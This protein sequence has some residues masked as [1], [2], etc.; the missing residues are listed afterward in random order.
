[1]KKNNNT[2]K[3][4]AA[5]FFFLG[6]LFLIYMILVEDEPGAVPLLMI[7]FGAGWYVYTRFKSTPK[8]PLSN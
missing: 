5:I 4:I 3:V 7:G 6:L 2:Q 8:D 1:M